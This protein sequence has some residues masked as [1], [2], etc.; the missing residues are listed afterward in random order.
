[1]ENMAT[2]K[3]I[4]DKVGVSV[5]T[6]SRVLN[7]DAHIS[8]NGETRRLIFET[9]D[10]LH[11]KKKVIYPVID[12]VAF[13]YWISD[14]EELYNIYFKSIR[15]ELEKQ[16]KQNNINIV[17]YKKRDGIKSIS[18]KTKAFIAVG[19]FTEKELGELSGIT[20]IGI[21][22]DTSPDESRFDC[23]RPNLRSMVYQIVD[24]FVSQGQ[25]KIGLISGCDYDTDSGMPKM[26]IREEAF[27]SRMSG[28]GLFN[29]DYVFIGK[30][31]SVSEGYRLAMEAMDR[32]KDGVPAAFC[33]GSDPFAIGALQ[34]FNERGWAIPQRV[35]FFSINDIG[36]AKYVSPPLTTFHI[37]V[38]LLCS[39]ALQLL[40][41]RV[42]MKRRVA[43]S[44]YI[45]GEIVFRK[46]CL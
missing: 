6:V 22:I 15:L 45:N 14:E 43:K 30:S 39:S 5:T 23:V 36:I 33:V 13:L 40:R 28:Y 31:F 17:R 37:D 25:T 8:V 35:G 9:A 10:N 34:A 2:L 24:F 41:E 21:F 27:R 26:D 7:N 12:N 4:A 32:L 18:P 29:E 1:M 42:T 20:P 19:R 3:E 11:Y 46:S 44:V 16:A 38:S